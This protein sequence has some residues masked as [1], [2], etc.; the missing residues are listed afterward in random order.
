MSDASDP[1]MTERAAGW[2]S[3]LGGLP[4]RTPLAFRKRRS[5]EFSLKYGPALLRCLGLQMVCFILTG[6]VLDL[7]SRTNK[8]CFIAIVSQWIV[9]LV[10]MGRRPLAP[11]KWDLRFISY[12]IVPL[13][14]AAP[15]I[16][17]LVWYF[18]GHTSQ[19]GLERLFP[20]R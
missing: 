7:E 6:L 17:D 11:T 13:T 2:P 14:L 3:D 10:M 15:W 20:K 19:N 5:F 18:I 8:L 1:G 4:D 9:V 16:A 12:G